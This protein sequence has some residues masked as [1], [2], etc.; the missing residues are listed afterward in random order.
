MFVYLPGE[1]RFRNDIAQ[2]EADAYRRKVLS[3][4]TSLGI[5]AIDLTPVFER[6]ESPKSL[7]DAHYSIEGNALVARAVAAAM[8]TG[9]PAN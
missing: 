3:V 8:R 2:I 6:H 5:T 1:H 4:V 9:L 7:F